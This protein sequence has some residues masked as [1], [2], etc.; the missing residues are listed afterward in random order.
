MIARLTFSDLYELF[1][2]KALPALFLAW[3]SWS[4]ILSILACALALVFFLGALAL[5]ISL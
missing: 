1:F 2:L 4:I 5:G 3:L